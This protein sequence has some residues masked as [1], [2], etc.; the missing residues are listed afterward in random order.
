MDV[1]MRKS[2]L[3][4]DTNPKGEF[5]IASVPDDATI[6]WAVHPRFGP[7][8]AT[9]PPRRQGKAHVDLRLQ[10]P[11]TLTGVVRADG[12]GVPGVAVQVGEAP[13]G[14]PIYA[15]RT[16]EQGHY[17]ITGLGEGVRIVEMG[18]QVSDASPPY[19]RRVRTKA[20]LQAGT[21]T[22]CDADFTLYDTYVEGRVHE[23]GARIEEIAR[24]IVTLNFYVY[25]GED[26]WERFTAYADADGYFALRGAP[27]GKALIRIIPNYSIQGDDGK[28]H[29]R[30]ED[31]EVTLND[32]VVTTL[33]LDYEM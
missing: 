28:Q 5:T 26:E 24:L 11:A 30:F 31:R 17:S 2:T 7:G 14:E 8:Q 1:H 4:A 33:N 27:P 6:L 18:R 10:P 19:I 13:G 15:A 20:V 29:M 32:G 25:T 16:D 23:N 3:H 21:E 9:I 12:V 22:R